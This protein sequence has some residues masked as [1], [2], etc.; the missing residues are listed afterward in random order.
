[1]MDRR[2]FLK[3]ASAATASVISTKGYASEPTGEIE[4]VGVLT[5]VTR[6]IGCRA[7]EKACAHANNLPEP[8]EVIEKEY[9]S[10][11]RTSVDQWT[12]VNRYHTPKG[13]VFV[14]K[15]CM[16]CW[17]PA[18][19][20]ACLTNAMYK[21]KEGPVIWRESKCMGCRYCMVA[22]PFMIPRFEYH[23][24]IPRIRKCIMC[25]PRLEKGKKPACVEVCP[26]GTL[27][28]D[29][30]RQL[31]ENGR[32]RIYA[33]PKTYIPKIYGEFEVGGTGWL[34]LSH[35]DFDKIDYRT[36]LGTTPYPEYTKGFLF[37]VPVILILW[38]SMML[39]LHFLI[40]RE[41]SM[42]EGGST[43]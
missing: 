39:A 17:Q 16:H 36:D 37:S 31:M 22:C 42:N 15:Q 30:K 34:Y 43:S 28:F 2:H 19:A 10:G 12:V 13:H 6:C 35:V 29:Q 11:R 38:P 41:N 14:K 7:C 25:W 18:C 8:P 24:P 33:N 21:T 32:S 5:D 1:M 26:T 20:S 40:S 23:S 27:S 4:F 9:E 3:L